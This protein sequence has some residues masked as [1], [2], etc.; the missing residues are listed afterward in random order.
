MLK[1]SYIS[2]LN[3]H[4]DKKL[5][6]D[7]LLWWFLTSQTTISPT[8]CLI[9]QILKDSFLSPP[10]FLVVQIPQISMKYFV[11]LSKV[12]L[13]QTTP[14]P[15]YLSKWP[16]TDICFTCG[17]WVFEPSIC[18]CLSSYSVS[19]DHRMVSHNGH[20]SAIDFLNHSASL[21]TL[22]QKKPKLRSCECPLLIEAKLSSSDLK[23]DQLLF[24]LCCYLQLLLT[25]WSVFREKVLSE[26][27]SY[28]LVN[29]KCRIL[30]FFNFFLFS[31]PKRE[32]AFV[33]R[34]KRNFLIFNSWPIPITSKRTIIVYPTD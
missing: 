12:Y 24:V 27:K 14:C 23:R 13:D 7:L 26:K 28:L 1:K 29:R 4:A 21:S 5:P 10:D 11:V 32:R 34:K 3:K 15:S 19:I 8:R 25:K 22:G 20:M 2:F 9:H 31:L 30:F 33:I 6:P 16:P 17:H 18:L